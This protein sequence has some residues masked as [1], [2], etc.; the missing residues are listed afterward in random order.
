MDR[1]RGI[2]G[3]QAA[4]L[5]LAGALLATAY[6]RGAF[7]LPAN[8]DEAQHLHVVWAWTQGLVPYRDVFD[9]HAP[10]YHWLVAPLFAALGE[11]ADVV[12]RMRLAG[13]AVYAGLLVATWRIGRAVWS[14]RV[15]AGAAV[16]VGA[17]PPFFAVA[18]QVRPDGLWA[19]LWLAAIAVAVGRPPSAR[20]A[21]LAGLLFGAA[22]AVSLKSVLLAAAAVVA[23]VSVR[24][25]RRASG[26][27]APPCRLRRLSA[28]LA[29][30]ALVPGASALYFASHGAA[31][32]AVYCLFEH[33]VLPASASGGRGLQGW[34]FPMLY[35]AALA[36]AWRLR[37]HGDP[38]R[39]WRR[40]GL[41]LVAAAYGLL[42]YA[43]WPLVTAQDRLPLWPLAAL[44]LAAWA[45]APERPRGAPRRALLAAALATSAAL[46][47]L[48]LLAPRTPLQAAQAR[49]ARVLALTRPDDPVMDAKGE[50]IY[51]RRPI[52]W[53]LET[54]TLRR[55]QDGLIADDI[56][57]RLA[58]TR[59]PL[60]VADRFPPADAAFLDAHYLP[61]GDGLY[62][63]GRRLGV[64]RAGETVRFD[65]AVAQ[66]YRLV[67]PHGE[68]AGELDGTPVAGPRALAAGTHVFT[69]T[70]A[71]AVALVW[72][73]ALARGLGA[74]L[75]FDEV[76]PSP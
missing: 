42:L 65:L 12:A 52:Y 16:L 2:S 45:F 21:F 3:R 72:S 53:V 58:A 59:T 49:L 61:V 26:D 15:G 14:D 69:A 67:A 70:A 44:L 73:S 8:S 40:G 56:P 62:V 6:V 19:L 55:M 47:A 31:S 60:V 63:A 20:R 74:E 34:L 7:A 57:A 50:S 46:L 29:G 51:R 64:L 33:N 10:L 66:T 4:A 13:I 27:R 18:G 37:A 9:N 75:L 32:A 28:A 54:I 39:R 68:A 41:W 5:A 1:G 76:S 22:F 38:A 43:Y 71:G 23:A 24:V 35:P 17:F 25:L 36:A 11:R 30:M 48:Q